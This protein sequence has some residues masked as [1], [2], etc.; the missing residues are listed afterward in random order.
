MSYYAINADG[1][2]Y[3][4]DPKIGAPPA[5][6]QV[7]SMSE[8][9][10]LVPVDSRIFTDPNIAHGEPGSLGYQLASLGGLG[11]GFSN[12][13]S[14]GAFLS[15]YAPAGA[16]LTPAIQ[17]AFQQ[18][19]SQFGGWSGADDPGQTALKILAQVEEPWA[20]QATQQIQASPEFAQS[21]AA[22]TAAVNYDPDEGEIFGIP[23]EIVLASLAI[24]G[25]QFLPGL[26]S[27][28]G[29]LEAL[30][31]DALLESQLG[32]LASSG[33]GGLSTLGAQAAGTASGSG[34][35]SSL[36][37]FINP[38]AAA[39]GAIRGALT[40]AIT[41]GNPITGALTGGFT[42][43]LNVPSSFTSG[44]PSSVVDMGKSAIGQLIRTGEINPVSLLTSAALGV[45]DPKIA[46]ALKGI[47]PN[48]AMP[49]VI[50]LANQALTGQD[51]NLAA[52][53]ASA[54][55][56]SVTPGIEKAFRKATAPS[57]FEYKVEDTSSPSVF[58]ETDAGVAEAL[59][60]PYLPEEFK[61]QSTAPQDDFRV[62]VVPETQEDFN[63]GLDFGEHELPD[64]T[65]ITIDDSG[66]YLATD[67]S[68][69]VIFTNDSQ[70]DRFET[71]QQDDGTRTV[72]D[73]YT[74]DV[75]DRIGYTD[76]T[77]PSTK[78][79][80]QANEDQD[81]EMLGDDPLQ[82]YK[83][84]G[85]IAD[86]ATDL[87]SLDRPKAYL[88]DGGVI[89][90]VDIPAYKE[91]ISKVVTNPR[92]F[93]V[94]TNPRTFVDPNSSTSVGGSGNKSQQSVTIQPSNAMLT[95]APWLQSQ[96]IKGSSNAPQLF[97]GLSSEQA[98]IR[99]INNSFS[100]NQLYP[101]QDFQE[102]QPIELARGGL[103]RLKEGGEVD[104]FKN[105][106]K[107]L[108]KEGKEVSLDDQ[109]KKY[110]SQQNLSN[111]RLEPAAFLSSKMIR[112]RPT[113]AEPIFSGIKNYDVPGATPSAGYSARQM[114]PL[115]QLDSFINTSRIPF[116]AHGGS[117]HPDL[118][119]V[120]A[121]RNFKI[122][123]QMIPGP[124]GRYYAKHAQRSFAVGG[125][126]T[127]Q[128]DDIPTMLSDGEYVFDADTVAALGDG[129]TKAGSA[130]LDKMREEIRKH[131]RSAPVNDIP[132][133]AKNPM[134]YLKMKQRK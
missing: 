122:N 73:T 125:A 68:G 134:A 14:V 31:G 19:Q 10:G 121:K 132:P 13:E 87:S 60:D 21:Q 92:T 115:R 48:E 79:L 128:S 39:S 29:S 116:A 27:G 64:G 70:P 4:Y 117:I 36:S 131:K 69:D 102:Y 22:G 85:L 50:S 89:D 103:T 101:T 23:K 80:A 100:Q 86:D 67:A 104:I 126:G 65:N 83:D 84:L 96:M 99:G 18:Q 30:I 110:V 90:A 63:F 46:D 34:G 55:G 106:D 6:T 66:S 2:G 81:K 20:Q 52:A 3:Q 113:R 47:V 105:I 16:D 114:Q 127:G 35:L 109:I 111:A 97:G 44:I 1:E 112:G 25:W 9:Q 24:A 42:G 98:Q 94:V 118:E 71:V 56:A 130:V 77:D 15:Q 43:G 88:P 51:L 108:K 37:S 58:D 5:G 61:S 72:V 33:S 49:A 129:S 41:G 133:K 59:A 95:A 76:G 53:G 45:I 82:V 75:V 12:P 7:F 124:E 28:A 54:L 8:E 26:F 40:S 38:S 93:K 119:R 74:G 78:T 91:N 62:T 57:N 123:K 32:A 107:Y 11:D 120:L 17:R